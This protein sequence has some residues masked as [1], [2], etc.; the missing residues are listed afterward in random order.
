MVN[1]LKVDVVIVGGGL[2][3]GTLSVALAQQNFN[4]AVI[5]RDSPDELLKPDLDGRTTAVSYGSKLIFEKLGIWEKVAHAAEP[6]L[7]IRVF[8]R[9]S[10]W[11]IYYDHRDI[12]SIPMGYIVEN[13][14]LRQGIFHR[15]A[16]LANHLTWMAPANVARTTRNLES[17]VV[18]LEDGRILKSPL[19]VGAEGRLSPTRDDA[20]LKT[21]RWSYE[22]MALIAHVVHEKPHL[23]TAWEIFQPQ[24]PFAILPLKTCSTT[25]AYRSGIVWTGSPDDIKRL[26]ELDDAKLTSELQDLFPYFGTLDVSGKRWSYPLSAMVAKETVDHRLAIVGDA[27]HTVHPVAGQG[28]NLG[29][30][31]A[32][33][34]A[35]VLGKARGLGL[36]IGSKSILED[37]QR[38]RRVD[39]LSILAMSD[40]MVRLFSNK[41]NILSFLRNTGL[42]IV[43]EIPPLKRRLM[44]HAM[45]I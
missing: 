37:Y 36:D 44:R 24:G 45:G 30:R 22:K 13:L 19:L 16:E 28:V 40:G 41:S 27:A 31:D 5:D 4:V 8:E 18:D 21:F 39:T 9:D 32:K 23:G 34:L 2:V 20:N 6:I 3:G 17:V 33:A 10:P 25:G 42:G 35:E 1:P 14:V 12:G 29:W 15:A 43:N 11:A 38:R 26:L 7:D